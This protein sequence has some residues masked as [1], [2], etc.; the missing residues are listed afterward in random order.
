MVKQQVSAHMLSWVVSKIEEY[1]SDSIE[2]VN[3]WWCD[4]HEITVVLVFI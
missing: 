3:K 2:R 1:K 4:G